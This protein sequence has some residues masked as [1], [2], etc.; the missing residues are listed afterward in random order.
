MADIK[1]VVESIKDVLVD[2][3]K[4]EVKYRARNNFFGS[5]IVSWF[6]WNWDRVAYFIFSADPILIR[7][8]TAKNLFPLEQGQHWYIF[9]HSHSL[10]WPLLTAS[11]FVLLYPV[12]MFVIAWIHEG[13]V[14]QI[15]ILNERKE[16]DRL[17]RNSDLVKLAESNEG[18]RAEVKASYERK[19]AED[20][21][22][23]VKA[24]LNISEMSKFHSRIETE[25]K[26]LGLERDGILASIKSLQERK[27]SLAEELIVINSEYEPVKN[28]NEKYQSLLKENAGLKA[29]TEQLKRNYDGLHEEYN[30]Y[31]RQKETEINNLK[32]SNVTVRP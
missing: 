19:I 17:K 14:K 25:I 27:D 8:L 7:I 6:F 21:E 31:R 16:S 2:P 28:N 29:E 10:V 5:F 9:W 15:A 3:L 12:L 32:S 13:V 11:V 30:D 1:E 26:T 18:A 20:T 4:D 24:R 23:A 22:A